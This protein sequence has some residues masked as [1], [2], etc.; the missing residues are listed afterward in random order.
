MLHYLQKYDNIDKILK[1]IIMILRAFVN[2]YHDIIGFSL[3]LVDITI[4]LL[5]FNSPPSAYAIL[6]IL[7][8]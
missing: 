3:E 7:Y 2:R 4:F 8:G 6:R 1:D 5:C